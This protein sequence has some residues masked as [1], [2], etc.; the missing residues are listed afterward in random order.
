MG[1]QEML[2]RAQHYGHLPPT[3]LAVVPAALGLPVGF[4]VAEGRVQTCVSF[5]L[6]PRKF[7]AGV[8]VNKVDLVAP[9][10]LAT[11]DPSGN[12]QLVLPD[13]NDVRV[14]SMDPAA[15]GLETARPGG[16]MWRR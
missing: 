16:F 2:R 5:D 12:A 11:D 1:N 15:H 6:D 4:L 9:A 14:E 13:L 8:T 10:R 7:P 3:G